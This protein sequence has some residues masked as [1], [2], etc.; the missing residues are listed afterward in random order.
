MKKLNK[1]NE[2]ADIIIYDGIV[3]DTQGSGRTR[4]VVSGISV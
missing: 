4:K 3:S 1:C 2:S